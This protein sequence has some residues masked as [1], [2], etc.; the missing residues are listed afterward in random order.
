MAART[1]QGLAIPFVFAVAVAYV[2][3]EVAGSR[4]AA[5]NGLYVSG[6][7]FGGFVTRISL[8]YLANSIAA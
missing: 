1:A 4:A 5:V 7:A 6:T 2:A 3:E 8:G